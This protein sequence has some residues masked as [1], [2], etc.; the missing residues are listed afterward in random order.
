[1]THID[2]SSETGRGRIFPLKVD[3]LE[4]VLAFVKTAGEDAGLDERR[5][6]SLMLACE[7]WFVNCCTHGASGEDDADMQ[8]IPYLCDD[9]LYVDMIDCGF[10]FDPLSHP[11]PDLDRPLEDADPGGLGLF[12][13]R[14]LINSV[15]WRRQ[16]DRNILTLSLEIG[17]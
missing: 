17:R 11:T 6:G 13:I 4:E 7:E 12:L 3:A 14:E 9:S 1:M 10:P 2:S 16:D 8:I 15:S 5:T